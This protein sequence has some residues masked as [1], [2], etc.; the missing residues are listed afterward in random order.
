VRFAGA[1]AQQAV[2]WGNTEAQLRQTV[3]RALDSQESDRK[4][5]ARFMH[6][7]VGQTLTAIGMRLD[8]ARMDLESGSGEVPARLSEVQQILGQMMEDVRRYVNELNPSTV[9][10]LGLAPAIERLGARLRER[11]QGVLRVHIDP[12]LRLDKKMASVFYLVAHEATENALKHSGCSTLEV[13]VQSTGTGTRLEVRDDGHGFDSGE[14]SGAA[15]GM[16]LL[17]MEHY[18]AQAGLE[19]SVVSSRDAGTIVRASTAADA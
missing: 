13:T 17:T 9:D 4:A 19:L 6:D 8:L 5:V 16:G 15:G 12:S 14:M 7:S 2:A 10:R 3:F 11:F 1:V 18:A